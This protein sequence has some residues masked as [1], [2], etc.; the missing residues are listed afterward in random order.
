VVA[1]A[2][3]QSMNGARKFMKAIKVGKAMQIFNGSE[4]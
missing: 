3:F 2:Q 4:H 1:F